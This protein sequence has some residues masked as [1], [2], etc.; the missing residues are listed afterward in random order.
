M[1]CSTEKPKTVHRLQNQRAG[2]KWSGGV[3]QHPKYHCIKGPKIPELSYCMSCSLCQRSKLLPRPDLVLTVIHPPAC[4]DHLFLSSVQTQSGE[5]LAS[6]NKNKSQA[7]LLG[8]QRRYFTR[9]GKPVDSRVLAGL[10]QIAYLSLQAFRKL[11]FCVQGNPAQVWLRVQ[12][13]APM[14][15]DVLGNLFLNMIIIFKIDLKLSYMFK[16]KNQ[17]LS[18]K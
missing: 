8:R 17:I 1:T 3:W 9:L 16:L 18:K 12:C 10:V 11:F 6:S 5:V 14:Q 13:H 2:K 4:R 7:R 15:D